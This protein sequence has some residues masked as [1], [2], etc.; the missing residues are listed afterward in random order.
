[1]RD[2]LS[3][4]AISQILQRTIAPELWGGSAHQPLHAL[5]PLKRWCPVDGSNHV[6]WFDGGG[7]IALDRDDHEAVLEPIPSHRKRSIDRGCAAAASNRAVAVVGSCHQSFQRVMKSR[8]VF[9]R[10][11]RRQ[12]LP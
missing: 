9:V 7:M 2:G 4:R 11:G 10:G 8:G 1:M 12:T 6:T 3:R 5:D